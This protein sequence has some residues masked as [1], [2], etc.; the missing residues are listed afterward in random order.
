MWA[1]FR[2]CEVAGTF[3]ADKRDAVQ[4]AITQVET[5]GSATLDGTTYGKT[6]LPYLYDLEELRSLQAARQEILGRNQAAAIAGRRVDRA[7]LD[8]VNEA[9]EKVRA[10]VNRHARKGLTVRRFVPIA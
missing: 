1:F 6:D 10:R 8:Q 4:T 7:S 9:I 2:S 5:V 3:F